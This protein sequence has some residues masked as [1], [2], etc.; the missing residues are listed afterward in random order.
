MSAEQDYQ[1]GIE[2]LFGLDSARTSVTFQGSDEMHFLRI[3]SLL[4]CSLEHCHS[5][6]TV[7]KQGQLLSA[8]VL[9]RTA[10]EHA[11]LAR[12]LDQAPDGPELSAIVID[13]HLSDF[14]N[15]AMD[16]GSI[17][18]SL[19]LRG[20]LKFRQV[21]HDRVPT[22]PNTLIGKFSQKKLL[23]HIYFLLS[24]SAHPISAFL[25]YVDLEEDGLTKRLRRNSTNQDSHS[26]FPFLF[27]ILAITLLTDAS[28]TEDKSL[29]EDVYRIT[30]E[31]FG[32]EDLLLVMP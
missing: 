30:S 1:K 9:V 6:F 8:R 24:Q 12:F 22:N 25:E 28:V 31:T 2:E 7:A 17:E 13:K 19:K 14:S 29:E 18:S 21:D 10:L 4:R 16:F 23:E 5:A 27:Q 3:Q 11:L 15:K 32:R 26:V 20:L